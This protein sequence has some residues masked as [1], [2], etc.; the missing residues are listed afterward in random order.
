MPLAVTFTVIWHWLLAG[1]EPPVK[2]TLELPGVA[3]RVPPHVSAAPP[4]ITTPAGKL[5]MNGA[6]SGAA[7]VAWLMR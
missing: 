7:T 6:V 5:S 4:E 3:V 1:I 2:V